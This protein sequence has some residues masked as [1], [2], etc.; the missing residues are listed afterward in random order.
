[1]AVII[2]I[3]RRNGQLIE[4]R[5]VDSTCVSIGRAYDNDVVVDDHYVCPHHLKLVALE[6]GWQVNDLG[7]VNGVQLRSGKRKLSGDQLN[8]GDR[9]QL[10]NVFLHIYGEAHPVAPTV[11]YI[12]FDKYVSVL[13]RPF[14]WPLLMLLALVP[15]VLQQWLQADES[16]KPMTLLSKSVEELLALALIPIIWVVISRITHNPGRYFTHLGLWALFS[17]TLVLALRLATI[18][19]FNAGSNFLYTVVSHVSEFVLLSLVCWASLSLATN[20]RSWKRHSAALGIGVVFI[21][22]PLLISLRSLDFTYFNMRPD[23]QGG[24]EP[25]IAQFARPVDEGQ[26][27]QQLDALFEQADR[28]AEKPVD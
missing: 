4:R 20:L 1:M 21:A 14:V 10:G 17:V 22:V 2:E 13:G 15:V 6:Q 12:G 26:L 3:R 5:R 7:S 24:L 23:Y 11:R 16:L 27:V 28:L 25:P 19:S 9:L 8:S 18:W